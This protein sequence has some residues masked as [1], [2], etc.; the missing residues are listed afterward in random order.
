[1]AAGVRA[2]KA[3]KVVARA[4]GM[5][6]AC[7]LVVVKHK[8]ER[9]I[10]AQLAERISEEH[11]LYEARNQSGQDVA[12]SRREQAAASDANNTSR[13]HPSHKKILGK[14]RASPASPSDST[15]QDPSTTQESSEWELRL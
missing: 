4:H 8:R 15:T 5:L 9:A 6:E 10:A 1:M 2:K 14:R 13:R 12:S 11:A 3:D 7:R